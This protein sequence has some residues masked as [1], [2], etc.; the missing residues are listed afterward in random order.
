[1]LSSISYLSMVNYAS[2][3]DFLYIIFGIIWVVFS[4]YNAQKKKKARKSNKPTEEKKPSFLDSLIDEIGIKSEQESPN[5]A[6]PYSED[7]QLITKSDDNNHLNTF[8]DQVFSYDDYYE[9]SNY[10]QVTDVNDIKQQD[11]VEVVTTTI[12]DKKISKNK[13]KNVDLRK[14]VIYSEIL[15]KKYF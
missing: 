9:E 7:D 10:S 4:Y 1:M 15:K 12:S 14:A 5:Y 11:K 13:V 6:D 2:F 3:E 8:N